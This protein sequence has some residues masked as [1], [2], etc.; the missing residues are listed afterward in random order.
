MAPLLWQRILLYTPEIRPPDFPRQPAAGILIPNGADVP[1]LRPSQVD[2][3]VFSIFLLLCEAV[4]N[5]AFAFYTP[6]W[7]KVFFGF[8]PPI[9]LTHNIVPFVSFHIAVLQCFSKAFFS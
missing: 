3:P 2:F 4:R 6:Y 5:E 7:K 1:F 8:P 9:P